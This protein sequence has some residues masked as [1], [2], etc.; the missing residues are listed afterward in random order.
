MKKKKPLNTNDGPRLHTYSISSDGNAVI[1]INT[2]AQRKV[3]H[4]TFYKI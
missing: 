2:S 1:Y 4:K 3:N